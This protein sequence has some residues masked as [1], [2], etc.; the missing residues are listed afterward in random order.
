MIPPPGAERPPRSHPHPKEKNMKPIAIE[1]MT[2]EQ[3]R[4]LPF[5]K[6][7]TFELPAAR[8]I[9]NATS[10]IYRSQ[11]VLGCRFT[12]RCDYEQLRMTIT[13]KRKEG[14]DGTVKD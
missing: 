7:R 4:A 9:I 14:A 8:D 6:A 1:K 2:R 12:V 3:L 13:R 11:H 10:L 5:G